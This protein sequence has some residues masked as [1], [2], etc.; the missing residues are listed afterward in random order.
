MAI[1]QQNQ[2]TLLEDLPPELLYKIFELCANDGAHGR[3]TLICLSVMN[4]YFRNVTTSRLFKHIRFHDL[5][6][7]PGDEI[8]HSIR[9]FMATPELLSHAR[10]VSLYLNRDTRL[11]S[12]QAALTEPYHYLI[13]PE[14]VEALVKMPDVTE[15]YIGIGGW[16]ARRCL[17]GLQAAVHPCSADL[18]I[19][20][21]TV[22]F[23]ARETFSHPHSQPYDNVDFLEALPH[24]KAFCF[25]GT[26]RYAYYGTFT[27]AFSFHSTI[28]S[29][30]TQLRICK[31]CLDSQFASGYGG[32]GKY[33]VAY[34][35]LSTVTPE[36]E[37]LS[38]LGGLEGV[39][40][41]CLLEQIVQTR[42]ERLKYVDITDEQMMGDR[43][44]ILRGSHLSDVEHRARNHPDNENRSELARQTFHRIPQLRRIC[45]VRCRVG[46]V[47]LRGYEDAVADSTG[48]I[49]PEINDADLVDIP[50]GW[51]HG[52]P[53]T[54]CLPFPGFTRVWE[55][56]D[57]AAE[58][59]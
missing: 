21:L 13:L 53:Q 38:I 2:V 37:H 7:S 22:S 30:L 51:R 52:V 31:T 17:Q 18:N 8:L 11:G 56:A 5:P 41:S 1:S 33:E 20:A 25:Q 27:A 55:S 44:P 12:D 23:N 54:S 9:R 15:L 28:A 39:R 47:Y 46:E 6:E 40:V 24:L 4:K 10:T 57:S 14:F 29:N 45:F 3:V 19:T 43:R 32:W 50:G 35:G 16:Q 59:G 36:L 34:L 48:Y 42:L 58:A 49:S 26:P